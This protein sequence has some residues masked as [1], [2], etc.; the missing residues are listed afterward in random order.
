MIW[1]IYIFA[2]FVFSYLLGLLFHEKVQKLIMFICVAVL[3]TPAQL[4]INSNE[5]APALFTFIFNFLLE[6]DYSLRAL[7]P[8]FLSLPLSMILLWL[9]VLVRKRFF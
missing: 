6:K 4:E 5:Y 2:S 1:L 7:R 9:F 3:L 8:L